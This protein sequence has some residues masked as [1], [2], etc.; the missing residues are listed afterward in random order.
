MVDCTIAAPTSPN[1]LLRWKTRDS[2]PPRPR[3]RSMA[4]VAAK[5]AASVLMPG[6]N[7]IAV[8]PLV[9]R[10]NVFVDLLPV[11]FTLASSDDDGFFVVI[12]GAETLGEAM[13]VHQAV[14]AELLA[15]RPAVCVIT[16]D[17]ELELARA[18]VKLWPC[19]K[20]RAILRQL[21]AERRLA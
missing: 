21:E 16:H 4:E 20:T 17:D 19:G 6:V 3:S 11:Y 10:P 5:I 2:A 12:S 1:R 7:V 8:G 13:R 18:L 9:R 15:H 14:L